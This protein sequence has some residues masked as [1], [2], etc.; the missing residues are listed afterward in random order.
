MTDEYFISIFERYLKLIIIFQDLFRLDDNIYSISGK[1]K[2]TQCFQPITSL[3]KILNI[4]DE[5][6]KTTL[7]SSYNPLE[8]KIIEIMKTEKNSLEDEL[9]KRFQIYNKEIFQFSK[10]KSLDSLE[11][12]KSIFLE[13]NSSLKKILVQPKL[14][15][16]KNDINTIIETKGDDKKEEKNENSLKDQSLTK[17]LLSETP[18]N[19][20]QLGFNL[21]EVK[22]YDRSKMGCDT[23][24][25]SEHIIHKTSSQNDFL[26][27]K[28]YT[29]S[30]NKSMAFTKET[31]VKK[32]IHSH[33]RFVFIL[34]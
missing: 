27:S 13:R 1:F 6:T 21:F 9:F 25:Q 23:P 20:Y 11:E 16:E 4:L 2:V 31:P 26:S 12:A 18:V 7:N 8:K 15:S 30:M 33:F 34:T 22:N 29:L 32:K 24:S 19:N 5:N 10:N 28:T 3:C 17:Q 14:H